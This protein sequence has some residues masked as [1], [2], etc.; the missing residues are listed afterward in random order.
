MIKVKGWIFP[1]IRRVY[2]YNQSIEDIK[3]AIEVIFSTSG[4]LLEGSDFSGYYSS[5]H[6]FVMASVIRG[7]PI[8]PFNVTTLWGK[9]LQMDTNTTKIEVKIKPPGKF[10]V[11]L[12]I[13]LLI[14]TIGLVKGIWIHSFGS[15]LAPVLMM[16]GTPY[17][18]AVSSKVKGERMVS[19]YEQNI[20]KILHIAPVIRS[21]P[22]KP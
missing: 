15:M 16:I 1:E 4:G 3:A 2:E 5:E 19:R 9:L 11:I 12:F 6:N 7:T 22:E 8:L 21:L 17:F 10:P 13:F 14:A 20:D 18:I